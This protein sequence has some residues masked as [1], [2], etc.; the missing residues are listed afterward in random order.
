M[1]DAPSGGAPAKAPRWDLTATEGYGGGN[2]FSLGPWMFSG[3]VGIYRRKKYVGGRPRGPRDRG[4]TQG[5]GRALH[6]RGPLVAPPTYFFLL[7]IPTYPENIRYGRKPLFPPPQPSVPVRSHLRAFSGVLPEGAL[8]I[9]G[10]YINTIA[11]PMM[12]E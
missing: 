8:I 6:P 11:S 9:E 5:G 3:Y 10:F 1:I 2:C 4:R 7:Y 12:C